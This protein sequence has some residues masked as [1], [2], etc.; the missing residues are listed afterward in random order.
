[1]DF[2]GSGRGLLSVVAIQRILLL[3]VPE[4]HVS[5]VYWCCNF[6]PLE[7]NFGIDEML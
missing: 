6:F 3:R 2:E 5:M 4:F 7:M 1:M